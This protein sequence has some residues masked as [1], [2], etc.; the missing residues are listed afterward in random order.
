[1]IMNQTKLNKSFLKKRLF[2]SFLFAAF[3]V[4][5]IAAQNQNYNI[6]ERNGQS[7][8]VY[9]VKS[10]EGLHAVSREFGI[11]VEE[12]KKSNPGTEDGLKLG[13]QLLIPMTQKTIDS[14]KL[15]PAY[16]EPMVSHLDK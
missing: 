11:S 15:C 14:V 2:F 4:A 8:Y 12:I 3:F 10:G 1:M 6:V 16:R 5:G 7:Y 9:L 13:Q